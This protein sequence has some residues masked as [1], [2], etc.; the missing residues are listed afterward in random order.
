NG[1]G[2]LLPI[3]FCAEETIE[4]GSVT[5]KDDEPFDCATL[6]NKSC[7]EGFICDEVN[8]LNEANDVNDCLEVICASGAPY[9]ENESTKATCNTL[10][11]GTDSAFALTSCAADG[12]ICDN[13]ACADV[14][15]DPGQPWCNG[16]VA[17]TCN[18]LGTGADD[19]LPIA[20]CA[21]EATAADQ[22]IICVIP[23]DGPA[24]CE[25]QIQCDGKVCGDDAC[26]GTCAP[27]CADEVGTTC[28]AGQCELVHCTPGQTFCTDDGK[29]WTCNAL[30]T[31]ADPEVDATDCLPLH[32]GQGGCEA[33]DAEAD[34]V[35]DTAACVC[36]PACDGKSCGDDGCGSVCGT[37]GDAEVCD[38]D[39]QCVAEVCSPEST[40][41]DGDTVR[42][43]D[44]WGA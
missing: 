30:G 16:E 10:G 20:D 5:N 38:G 27:G 11:T 41:C 17:A 4:C 40:Y 24:A 42:T 14:I 7:S 26:G 3:V 37:C 1:N 43:C 32:E 36:V 9:C 2:C 35:T 28:D 8:D 23:E 44:A 19:A 18:A 12:K 34:G 22:P 39:Q 29:L 31:G 33:T 15:C 21:A 25:C 13:G 6:V